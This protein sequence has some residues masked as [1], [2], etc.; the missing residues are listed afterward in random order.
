MLS[1]RFARLAFVLSVCLPFVGCGDDGKK[2]DDTTSQCSDGMDN[3]A[4]GKTDFPDDPG[5]TSADDDSED[6]AA[7]A[8]CS[9]GRDNDNDGKTD[10]PDDPGCSAPNQDDE[11]DDCPSG[12]GCAACGNGV[13]DDGNGLTDYPND[14]GCSS[15][16]DNSEAT[17]DPIACGAGLT[18][19]PLPGSGVA[20][21]TFSVAVSSSSIV[22]GCGE[23]AGSPAYAYALVVDHPVVIVAT[24]ADSGTTDTVVDVRGMDCDAPTAGI[25]C[26]DDIDPVNSVV[27]STVTASLTTPGTYYI[28]VKGHDPSETG[29]FVLTVTQFLG[30]GVAC[31]PA[32]TCG[33]GLV[34]RT[35][36][37]GTG[38]VCTKPECS[39]G[40]NNDADAVMDYPFDPG[41]S[42]P[43]DNS[44]LD[45]CP[46]G[47][48]CPACSNG[49]DDDNDGHVDY[50]ADPSCTSAAGGSE[51]CSGEQDPIDALTM[52]TT[53]STMIGMHDDRNYDPA[54][55][56]FGGAT[57]GLDRVFTITVPATRSLTLDTDSASQLDTVI[58]LLPT[59]CMEPN[60][61][62]DDDGAGVFGGPSL[63]TATNLPAGTYV[64]SVDLYGSFTTPDAFDVH[65]SGT[66]EQGASCEPVNTLNG[67]LACPAANPCTGTVGARICALAVCNDGISNDGDGLIDYP[68][69]P[70]C[71]SPDDPD[72]TDD[73]PSGPNCPQCKNGVDDDGTGGTDYPNDPDCTSAADN[74]ELLSVC[75]ETDP[76]ITITGPTMSGDSATLHDD[77]LYDEV[78]CTGGT[79]TGSTGGV[80]AA[81]LLTIP[82]LESLHRVVAP[83]ADQPRGGHVHRA[84]RR[85]L[86]QLVG[87][88]R[89]P[90]DRHARDRP[91]LRA[92]QHARRR[93]PLL[94]DAPVRRHRRRADLPVATSTA[95]GRARAG[96]G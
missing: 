63:L 19:L 31:T 71:T 77:R 23:L 17:V 16:G 61:T 51:A 8:Q 65:V 9:D 30:E 37:G 94:G 10:Y 26:N 24:T 50:P 96:D 82:T 53:P 41:C 83:H 18:I 34:C 68:N 78:T 75:S 79:F 7:A 90:H 3:D 48:N 54:C 76:N 1:P 62:C 95:C 46:S 72:E 45:D 43:D 80:D 28:I 33:P 91:E 57:G 6:S 88:V 38:T 84:R 73:C 47:P 20:M 22:S 12:P 35:P 69:D 14:P 92:R 49:V 2:A 93:V 39:D 29:T 66:L 11:V 27:T 67:A 13:D 36:V 86:E 74:S 55:S 85:L 89:A 59:T 60:I 40:A 32:D 56:S 58:T 44:E 42:S 21:G 52:P 4:D 5:C 25:A 64:L 15:A 87:H 70:G 81:Y